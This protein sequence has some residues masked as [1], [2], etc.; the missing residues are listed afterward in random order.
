MGYIAIRHKD[1]LKNY[2]NNEYSHQIELMNLLRDQ[3]GYS[4]KHN[5]VW[6]GVKHFTRFGRTTD[7][8]I[9]NILEETKILKAKIEE[10]MSN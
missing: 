2:L 7:E 6:L 8:I 3:K 9:L 4:D 5:N 10:I 1:Y